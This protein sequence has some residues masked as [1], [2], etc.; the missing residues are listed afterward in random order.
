[1]KAIDAVSNLRTLADLLEKNGDTEIQMSSAI[2]WIYNKESFLTLAKDFPRPVRKV[3]EERNYGNFK[4]EHG[5]LLSTGVIELLIPNSRIC[6]LIEPARPAV[7]K[8]PQIL[9]LEEEEELK[10]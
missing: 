8:Y 4:L 9:S 3:R 1:M 5:V 7:Y 2:V 10:K 6:E